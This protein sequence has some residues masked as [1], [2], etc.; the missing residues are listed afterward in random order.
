MINRE[1]PVVLY[2]CYQTNSP[3]PAKMRAMIDVFSRLDFPKCESIT[4]YTDDEEIAWEWNEICSSDKPVNQYSGEWRALLPH[5]F[6]FSL[7]PRI[8]D[9]GY[10][11]TAMRSDMKLHLQNKEF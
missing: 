8:K 9:K 5:L 10:L 3:K 6:Q 11:T 2:R 4:I 7:K 1:E